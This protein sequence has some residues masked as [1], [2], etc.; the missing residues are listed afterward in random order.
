MAVQLKPDDSTRLK[1]LA[2][3]LKKGS[4]SPN[5]RQIKRYSGFHKATIKSS[6]DFLLKEGVLQGF[7][8]KIDFNKFGFKLEVIEMLHVDFAE[9]EILKQFLNAMD[10]DNHIYMVSGVIGGRNWN[11]LVRHF[12]RD[13][14]S[15]HNSIQKNYYEK[16]KGIYKLIRDRQLIYVTAP[17]YKTS[18]RTSSIIDILEKEKG[19]E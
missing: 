15:F 14:E 4:V 3:L 2:A 10:K 19:I 17:F 8:P 18:S 9:K 13:I 6:V 5:L 11:L 12:Y 16:I 7:G 1:T